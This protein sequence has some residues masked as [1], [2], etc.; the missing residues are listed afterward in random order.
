M[1]NIKERVGKALVRTLFVML[2][3]IIAAPFLWTWIA[4]HYSY[5]TGERAG[6]IQKFSHKGWICKSWEGEL[7]LVN[8]PGAMPE[9]FAFTVRDEA[10]A[11]NIGDVIGKRVALTYEQHIGIPSTCFGETQYFITGLRVL[12]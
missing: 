7:A 4:L 9:I 5:S 1:E 10:V 2:A 8:L 6:F 11:R 3:V 12:E